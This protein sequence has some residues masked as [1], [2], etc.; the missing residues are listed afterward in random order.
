MKKICVLIPTYNEEE[1]VAL[2]SEELIKLFARELPQ[3]DY[4]VM[5]IDNASQ[6]GTQGII[7]GLCKEN[8]KIKAIFNAKDFGQL[9]SPFYG[10]CHSTGDCTVLLCADFQDPLELIPKFV[11]EWE[12]GFKIVCGIKTSSKENK[13]M[14]F[15][16]SIY[17]R[18]IRKMSSV[19]QIEHFT[20]FGLYDKSFIEVLKTIDDPIPFL[21]GI[22]AELGFDRKEI[23]Y[24]QEKRK[25][26]KSKN[27][28]YRLY[29]IA[30]L[31]FT[32]YTKIGLRLAMFIGFAFSALS[33]L[34]ALIYL[35]MKLMFWDN[36]L[37]G[38]API[39][40][41]VF[42]LG[43]LQ[44]FFIGL[45]GEYIISINARVIKRP[46]VIEKKRLNFNE[47]AP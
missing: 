9:K 15:L 10:L 20:G 6:D 41:G 16:R 39:L 22:V 5:F 38:T 36:F 7:E 35:V 26:G 31:S 12:D 24:T 21:R 43:S 47:E 40:I 45:I 18:A 29:D 11:K 32:S 27:N 28:F 42:A 23:E 1:N 44:L 17:Y 33:L 4:D 46:L 14:Y 34:T 25:F 37:A 8:P 3:Y 30:M 2:L 13:L 19:D